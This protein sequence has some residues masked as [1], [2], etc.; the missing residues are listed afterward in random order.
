MTGGFKFDSKV[1]DVFDDMLV[2]SVPCYRMVIG[3]VASILGKFLKPGDRVY[4][5]GCSTGE[6]LAELSRK[7]NHLHLEFT[8]IDNSPAMIEKAIHKA[9][10]FS[11]DGSLRFK[12][13]D[14]TEFCLHSS[15]GAVIMNYTLQFIDPK[16]RAKFLSTTRNALRPGG[17]LIIS[18]K[19]VSEDPAMHRAY[20][21]FYLEFK[22]RN[23]YSETEISHKRQALENVLVPFSIKDNLN[24]LTAAGFRKPESFFQ[25]FNF[26]SFLAVKD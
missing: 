17:V 5:L 22:R 25:W 13:A 18:E 21:D 24:L 9:E 8:G 1:A 23:G 20:I 4:D 11:L 19:T 2:R 12:E 3:M 7:L 16:K 10:M 26:T 15:T 6:T 14:I